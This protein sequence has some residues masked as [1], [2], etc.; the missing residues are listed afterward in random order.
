MQAG[1]KGIAHEEIE[2]QIIEGKKYKENTHLLIICG[3]EFQVEVP[4]N[5][6]TPN[7]K[8]PNE[9]RAA[10]NKLVR[11]TPQRKPTTHIWHGNELL[12]CRALCETTFSRLF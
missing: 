7:S 3:V 6:K 2:E 1:K 12:I 4:E 11:Q 9:V 5:E 10:R 8:V